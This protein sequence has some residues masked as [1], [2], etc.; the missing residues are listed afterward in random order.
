VPEPS[1]A[2]V[3]FG[4]SGDLAYKQIFPALQRL[5]SE[6]GLTVPIV[7]VANADWSL[8]ELTARAEASLREDGCFDP[9]TFAPLAKLLRYVDGDYQDE[10]T[11]SSLR[12][13]LGDSR[14]PLHYLAIPPSLF[15]V[16]A[17][18][19]AKSGCNDGARIVVEKPFGRDRTTA[20]ALNELLHRYFTEDRVFRI[21]HYLGKDPV[22]NIMYTRF[23]NP[24]FEPVWNRSYVRSFQITMAEKFG[25]ESRGAFYDDVGTIRDV[26]QNHLLAV[27][28]NLCMEPPAA[29][30]PD[31]I[32]DARAML[33]KAVRPLT[34]NDV[35][36]GQYEGYREEQGVHP[37]SR[38]ETFVAARLFIDTWRWADVPIYIRTG[39]HLPETATE[40]TV[41]FRRPPQEVFGEIIPAFSSHLRMRISPDISI[42]MGVRVKRPG[43]RMVGDDVELS[44]SE[45]AA[46]VMPPYQRLLGDALKGQSELFT[47]ADLVDAEWRIVD[48]I[49]GDVVPAYPYDPG[50]WGPDEAIGMIA[51]DGP[52]IDPKAVRRTRPG[53]RRY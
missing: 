15:G 19:L 46:S 47:R 38:T 36:R 29:D 17:E 25:V 44:L 40:V 45:H 10:S 39:K 11:F 6:G 32:R 1:D 42:G 3:F 27:V 43:D 50:T 48:P 41:Q 33:L 35:V 16:V 37:E 2:L 20:E 28:A 9:A 34:P 12:R 14:R 7:G 52:W 22:Q 21:D 53:A 13:E 18:G 49:L 23:A 4:A 26:L 31:A 51:G 5:V 8:A 24:I 30:D